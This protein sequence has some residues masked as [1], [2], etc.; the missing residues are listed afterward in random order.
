MRKPDLSKL[1]FLHAALEDTAE[2]LLYKGIGGKDGISAEGFAW[3]LKYLSDY[4]PNIRVRI[5]SAGGSVV[6]GM[7]IVAAIQESK[8]HITTIVDGLAASM[9]SVI[10]QAGRKRLIKDFG[11]LML[12]NP[13][14]G[15]AATDEVNAAQLAIFRASMLTIYTS[16]SQKT[17][18]EIG[19]LLDAETWMDASQALE[20]GLADEIQTTSQKISASPEELRALAPAAAVEVFASLLSTKQPIKNKMLDNLK[21]VFND[22]TIDEVKALAK[23][24]D[25]VNAKAASDTKVQELEAK[26]TTLETDAKA[27][28]EAAAK[29]LVKVHA[30]KLKAE[31]VPTWEEM[32]TKDYDGAKA[33]LESIQHPHPN[34][35]GKAEEADKSPRADWTLKDWRQKD[36]K[37]LMELKA[38]DPDAFAALIASNTNT[39]K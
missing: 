19:A 25:L 37:G 7:A 17:A 26:V 21:A 36:S 39:L 28:R 8:S 22:D 1:Q 29:A 35:S 4:Y 6:E 2:V 15:D 5:N 30:G 20:Y 31:A 9:A 11:V 24:T 38:S 34:L 12:H 33:A 14:Y 3:E 10:F 16:K 32:A 27:H 18:E 13:S 23:I